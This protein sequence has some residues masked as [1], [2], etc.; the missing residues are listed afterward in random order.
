VSSPRAAAELVA[1]MAKREIDILIG[2]QIVAKGH[3]FPLLTFVGVIDADLGLG[4]GDLRA[5]ERTYQV[6]SQVAGRAGRAEHPG[7]VL[8]QTYFPDHPVMEALVA[9]DREG[10]I[11]QEKAARK[12]HGMPPFARLAGVIV[13]GESE[14]LA[15]GVARDLGRSAPRGQDINVLG[16]APAPLAVLRGR[17]RFRLLVRARRNVDL[18]AA[19]RGWLGKAAMPRAVRLQVDID[20]VSFL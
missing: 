3:H 10:F 8:L 9:G 14:A 2:T 16:P 7:S 17:Y 15:G 12:Q 1:S 11:E 4:G 13:S 5:A 19:L 18:Q 20:P 6:L